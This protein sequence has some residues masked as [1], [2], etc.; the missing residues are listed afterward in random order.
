MA[1]TPS[2]VVRV[3][4][5]DIS[6]CR[7]YVLPSPWRPARRPD[8][9]AL[10]VPPAARYRRRH[11]APLA[12]TGRRP[13]LRSHRGPTVGRCA[14]GAGAGRGATFDLLGEVGGLG[15]KGL[16]LLDGVD[17]D[18]ED[19]RGISGCTARGATDRC[20]LLLPPFRHPL[21]RRFLE[22]RQRPRRHDGPLSGR[23]VPPLQ[24]QGD[25]EGECFGVVADRPLSHSS[26][27]LTPRRGHPFRTHQ[28]PRHALGG[29]GRP[30]GRLGPSRE[31][32]AINH[33]TGNGS[34]RRRTS[35]CDGTG[36]AGN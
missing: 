3:T 1:S 31:P 12:Q 18:L 35:R 6:L 10:A 17:A 11:E 32:P 26:A 5:S 21:F 29:P 2:E 27:V 7:R 28:R 13:G 19:G 33:A 15:E 23:Q 9:L 22:R 25:D 30:P 4:A 24:V 20:T 8:T 34:G 16:G 36:A 14:R